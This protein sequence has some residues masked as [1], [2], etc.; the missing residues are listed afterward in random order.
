MLALGYVVTLCLPLSNIAEREAAVAAQQRAARSDSS[1]SGSW[2]T[3]APVSFRQ[4]LKRR[5]SFGDL[6]F[7]ASTEP[8]GSEER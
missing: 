8:E 4:E 6:R 3:D 5:G 1:G 7:L 2:A